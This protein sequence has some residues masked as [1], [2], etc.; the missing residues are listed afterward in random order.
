MCLN[1]GLAIV[2]DKE[3]RRTAKNFYRLLWPS[4]PIPPK[5]LLNSGKVERYGEVRS[6]NVDMYK[7]R[8]KVICIGDEKS[9]EIYHCRL[10]LP[11]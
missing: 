7:R 9:V 5:S 3:R 4:D 6:K 1:Q 11:P 10:G 2:P 8:I